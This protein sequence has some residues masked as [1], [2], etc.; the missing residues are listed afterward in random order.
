M[1]ASVAPADLNLMKKNDVILMGVLAAAALILSVGISLYFAANTKMAEAVVY[2]DGKEQGRY[3]LNHPQTVKISSGDGNYNVLEIK[4]NQA[5]ITEASC[6]DKLCVKHRP[7]KKSGES[8]VCL[9]NRVVV[10]IENGDEREVD[11]SASGTGGENHGKKGGIYGNADSSC[12]CIF[13]Y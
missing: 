8:L 10:E 7:V 2:V 9:P 11:S 3:A 4:E 1:E 6:P 12:I 13:L 5:E